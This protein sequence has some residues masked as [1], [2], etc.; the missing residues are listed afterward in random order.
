MKVGIIGLPQS[1]KTTVFNALTGAHGEVGGFHGAG[2]IAV[3]VLW[4]PDERLDYLAGLFQPER[5]VA[6]S[7]EFEDIAGG[8][9]QRGGGD[10]SAHALAAMRDADALLMVLRCFQ[11]P[12]VP[13]V[14]GSVNAA[15]DLRTMMDELLLADLAVIEKRAKA[16]RGDLKRAS[17]DRERQMAELALLERCA[18]AVENGQEILSVHMTPEEDKMLRHYAFL[19]LK[20]SLC[21]LNVGEEEPGGGPDAEKLQALDL[22]PIIMCG[23]LEMEIMDLEDKDRAP[24][25]EELGVQELVSDRVVRACYELMGLRSFFTYVGREVRAWTVRAGEDA[26]AAAGKVHTDMARGFIRAE[27]VAFDDLKEC[28]SVQEARSKGKVR[29][30]GKTYEVQNGDVITFRFGT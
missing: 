23:E 10:G 7:I 3:A 25:M 19:T 22:P 21:L 8:F 5:A 27:V 14:E 18:E 13:H 24:F 4:V 1:G 17:P 26:L 15:R 28:G 6:A 29:L 11:N 2:Q 20:P 12:S 16:L 9:L 30:E